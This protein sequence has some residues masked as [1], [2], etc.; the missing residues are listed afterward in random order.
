MKRAKDS[1]S[2][3]ESSRKQ[4]GFWGGLCRSNWSLFPCA[5]PTHL[6]PC[7]RPPDENRFVFEDTAGV[8]CKRREFQY[9]IFNHLFYWLAI[10][11]QQRPMP[12]LAHC[13]YNNG[14]D[15]IMNQ[16]RSDFLK[17]P[18]HILLAHRCTSQLFSPVAKPGSVSHKKDM[19]FLPDWPTSGGICA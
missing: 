13:N 18:R 4:C 6:L 1:F 5:Q 12:P 10:T 7:Q 9:F 8:I 16:I 11:F 14:G 2:D 3:I 15:V 19:P 17:L